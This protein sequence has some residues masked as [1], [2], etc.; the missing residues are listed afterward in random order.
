M[1]P[2]LQTARLA[3]RPATAADLDALHRLLTDPQVRRYLCDG[4][5]FPREQ[6]AGMLADAAALAPRGLGWWSIE[7]AGSA[8]GLLALQPVSA[9][10]LPHVPHL[11]GE[12]EPTVA[13]APAHWHRGY[14]VEALGA[15]VRHAFGTLGLPRLVAMTD[16]PNAASQAMLAR[17][18]FVK[19][20]ETT[21]PAWPQWTYR[22][23]AA[24]DGG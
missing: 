15:A 3:L 17:S 8:I 1:L 5:V 16:A 19:T 12:V 6:V 24:G 23:E 22:L 14:A 4:Q 18:G 11:A 7:R 20:G 9:A 2:A 13:L 21:G 10:A